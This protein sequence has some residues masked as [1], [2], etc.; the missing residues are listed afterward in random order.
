MQYPRSIYLREGWT[1]KKL[2]ENMMLRIAVAEPTSSTS[3]FAQCKI[4]DFRMYVGDMTPQDILSLQDNSIW[5]SG[6]RMKQ[7]VDVATDETFYDKTDRDAGRRNCLWYAKAREQA[8]QV[9]S[10]MS[11]KLMCPVTCRGRRECYDGSLSYTYVQPLPRRVFRIFDRI[12]YLSPRASQSSVLCPAKSVSRQAILDKCRSLA[13]TYPKSSKE[14]GWSDYFQGYSMTWKEMNRLDMTDCD[15]LAKRLDED[16]CA[17]DDAWIAEFLKDYNQAGVYSIAFWI[18]PTENSRGMPGN[19]F[20]SIHLYSRISSPY[21]IADWGESNPEK[22]DGMRMWSPAGA[23]LRELTGIV[24][25]A[26]SW[27][28]FYMFFEKLPGGRFKSCMTLNAMPMA[29]MEG[30]SSGLSD[31]PSS[32]MQAVEVTTEALVSPIEIRTEKMSPAQLQQYFYRKAKKMEKMPGPITSELDR[33]K[34]YN[35]ITPKEIVKYDEKLLLISPPLLF[36]TRT[37]SIPCT[38]EVA[39]L[40]FDNQRDLIAAA[41]CTTEGA[42]PGFGESS[43]VYTCTSE[44]PSTV[45]HYGL[46]TSVLAGERGYAD[47]LY[48]YSDNPVVVRNGEALPTEYFFDGDTERA[49]AIGVFFSPSRAVTTLLQLETSFKGSIPKAQVSFQQYTF[50]QDSD[51]PSLI[52]MTVVMLT[53]IML[54]VVLNLMLMLVLHEERQGGIEAPSASREKLEIVYDFVQV[55]LVLAFLIA[56]L[57]STLQSQEKAKEIIGGLVQVPFVDPEISFSDKVE[58]FFSSLELLFDA[59]KYKSMLD[60]MGL[61]L[62]FTM[63]FRILWATKVHPRVGVLIGTL[64]NGFDDLFH[65]AVLFLLVFVTFAFT[66]VWV[67]GDKRDDMADLS[68]AMTTQANL[69]LSCCEG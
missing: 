2:F 3:P 55:L 67:F 63:L 60:K 37:K 56:V 4:S 19:F 66:A 26:H 10:S 17:W 23:I 25:Y 29:C 12:M 44:E 59:L 16:Q 5:A 32:F 54:V 30:N 61:V 27:T 7:C 57:K 42:C 13:G 20:P 18:H 53:S 46:N 68:A 34:V 15:E 9:C 52:A 39:N 31:L 64:Q 1:A 58:R 41:Q 47:F 69:V 65:F 48:T 35:T 21:A 43:E 11:A 6:A 50:L 22:E 24:D 8:P 38:D 45:A 36:Q 28:L 51:K 14:P 33:V 40:V 49:M 62:L